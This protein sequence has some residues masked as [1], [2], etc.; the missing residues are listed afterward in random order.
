MNS[1]LV[2]QIVIEVELNWE[3][4]ELIEYVE[5]ES[6]NVAKADTN[7]KWAKIAAVQQFNATKRGIRTC[8]W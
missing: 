4:K 1:K 6:V 7:A 3:N 8:R 5:A 2:V